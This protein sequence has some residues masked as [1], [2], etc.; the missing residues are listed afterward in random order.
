MKDFFVILGG[1]GTQATESFVHLLNKRTPAKKDQDYLNYCLFNH[2]TVPDRTAYIL[3][4]RL[5]SPVEAL[6]EDIRQL[7]PL[8]PSFFVLTCNTAHYFYNELQAQTEIPILHMPRIAVEQV[9]KSYSHLNRKIRVGLLATTGTVSSG[10]YHHEMEKHEQIELVMAPKEIQE[11]VM[12]LIYDDIKAQNYLNEERYQYILKEMMEE[13]ACDVVILG[14][15]ELSLMQAE[16]SQ[17]KFP[18]IDAQSELVD[19]TI[20]RVLSR[21]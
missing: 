21:R 1:M 13:E 16:T 6:T 19:A 9:V 15:T 17:T 18:V 20:E 2:A 12:R 11:E 14:C 3:D 8:H 7:S 5:D 4:T 10:V